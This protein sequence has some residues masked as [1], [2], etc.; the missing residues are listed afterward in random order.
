MYEHRL[1][2][3]RD[4]ANTI[5]LVGSEGNRAWAFAAAIHQALTSAAFR[6]HIASMNDLSSR[7]SKAQRL[8][9]LTSTYGDDDAPSSATRF[10][11]KLAAMNDYVPPMFAVLGVGDRH[12]PHF[13]ADAQ[14]VHG[15]QLDALFLL[16]ND[17]H[18]H[19]IGTGLFDASLNGIEVPGGQNASRSRPGQTPHSK[20]ED[21][22]PVQPY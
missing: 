5:I 11:S 12:F 14:S 8:I 19:A 3:V 9:V 17:T 21:I 18:I 7:H 10:L 13:C 4:Q 6:V 2:V 16:R 22:S 15:K 1:L 20:A